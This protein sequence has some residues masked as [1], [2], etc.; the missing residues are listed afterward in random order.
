MFQAFDSIRPMQVPIVGGRFGLG[1]KKM[2]YV[3]YTYCPLPPS[4]GNDG[5]SGATAYAVTVTD[6]TLNCMRDARGNTLCSDG[7]RYPPGCPN[8]P[9]EQYFTPGITPDVTTGSQIEGQQ[10]APRAAG[11]AGGASSGFPLVPVAVG[12]GLLAAG[13]AAFMYF[14]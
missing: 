14:K 8:T 4:G 5:P 2:T 1:S 7:K 13:L 11:S 3:E 9:P 12:G 6:P 10:P